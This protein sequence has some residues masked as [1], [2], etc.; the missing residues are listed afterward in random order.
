MNS[1]TQES[2][3][4]RY[5]KRSCQARSPLVL[6]HSEHNNTSVISTKTHCLPT[7]NCTAAT[8]LHINIAV[9]RI[10]RNQSK[11]ASATR[12]RRASWLGNGYRSIREQ[13]LVVLNLNLPI[14][15]LVLFKVCLGTHSTRSLQFLASHALGVSASNGWVE[16]FHIVVLKVRCISHSRPLYEIFCRLLAFPSSSSSSTT[17]FFLLPPPAL[18]RPFVGWLDSRVGKDDIGVAACEE[19]VCAEPGVDASRRKLEELRLN[20]RSVSLTGALRRVAVPAPLAV[21]VVAVPLM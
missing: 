21:A 14:C 6:N 10:P 18:F 17:F 8:N 20:I 7:A 15:R 11:P 3:D 19:G 2:L 4:A 16:C 5:C 12:A 13:R 1:L 9:V